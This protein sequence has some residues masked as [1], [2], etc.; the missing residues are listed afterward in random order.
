MLN[1]I[2]RVLKNNNLPKYF[3]ILIFFKRIQIDKLYLEFNNYSRTG[4]LHKIAGI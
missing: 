1:N 2:K 4:Y 3:Q